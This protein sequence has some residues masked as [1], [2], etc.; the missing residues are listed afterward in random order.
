MSLASSLAQAPFVLV[1]SICLM[2]E[3]LEAENDKREVVLVTLGGRKF[4]IYMDCQALID[5]GKTWSDR[6]CATR[7]QHFLASSNSLHCHLS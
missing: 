6:L 3:L 5:A 7:I 4:H 2:Q 1:L